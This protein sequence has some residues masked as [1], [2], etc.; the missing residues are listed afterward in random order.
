MG[1]LLES[2]GAVPTSV[3]LLGGHPLRNFYLVPTTITRRDLGISLVEKLGLS[4]ILA[5]ECVDVL[6]LALRETILKGNRIEARG[7]GTWV[8]KTV[9]ARDNARNPRTGETV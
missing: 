5:G 1:M 6:F 3:D 4:I 9:K 2:V 8:V 7:F